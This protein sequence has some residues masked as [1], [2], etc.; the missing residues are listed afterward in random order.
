MKEKL[1]I[2]IAGGQDSVLFVWLFDADK[3]LKSFAPPQ[4]PE[5]KNASGKTAGN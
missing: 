5:A 4:P 3:P 2:A 1:R